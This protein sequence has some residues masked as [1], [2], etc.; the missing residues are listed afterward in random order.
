[1]NPA[2]LTLLT[3]LICLIAQATGATAAEPDPPFAV[4]SKKHGLSQSEV[5]SLIQDTAGYLWSGSLRG[6]NRFDG[7]SFVQVTVT[8]GL[9]MNAQNALTLDFQGRIW[10]GDEGGGLSMLV[11]GRVHSTYP[12]P[13]SGSPISAMANSELGIIAGTVGEGTWLFEFSTEAWRQLS[14]SPESVNQ[15]ATDGIVVAVV[16]RKHELTL[17]SIDGTLPF[18]EVPGAFQ[19]LSNNAEG[20]V[21]VAEATG[22]LFGITAEGGLAPIGQN[23]GASP[24]LMT[25]T[26]AGV[27]WSVHDRTL[28]NSSGLSVKLPWPDALS[29]VVDREGVVWL[30][31]IGGLVRYL[32]NTFEHYSL[33][34]NGQA[35]AVWSISQDHL[36]NIWFGTEDGVLVLDRQ[37]NLVNLSKQ[38]KLPDNPIIDIL[39]GPSDTQLVAIVSKG[40]YQVNAQTTE[41]TLLPGTKDIDSWIIAL[42]KNRYLWIS[43]YENGLIRYDCYQRGLARE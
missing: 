4:Y 24:L 26:P 18:A 12:P 10:A 25:I 33:S 8:D 15:L 41:A 40:I 2:K 7:E 19:A 13:A 6:L 28:M 30:G 37:H 1:M 35:E 29:L 9:R 39:P 36:G 27:S 3:V 17:T 38:L 43:I 23:I 42:E 34:D 5:T 32:G 22:E 16:S 11:N 31:Y 21:I 20:N 14:P